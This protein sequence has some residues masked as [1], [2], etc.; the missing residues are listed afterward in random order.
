MIF[1]LSAPQAAAMNANVVTLRHRYNP[2]YAAMHLA[3]QGSAA[4]ERPTEAYEG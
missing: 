1:A 3:C 4:K 2:D